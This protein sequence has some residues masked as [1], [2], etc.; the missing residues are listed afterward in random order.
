MTH[1]DS[2]RKRKTI[3]FGRHPCVS[4][5]GFTCAAKTAF[6][7]NQEGRWEERKRK[8]EEEE[9]SRGPVVA[10]TGAPLGVTNHVVVGLTTH[11]VPR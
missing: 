9:D 5:E 3:L 7:A 1:H 10:T 6:I 11:M 2:Y 8:E 4:K